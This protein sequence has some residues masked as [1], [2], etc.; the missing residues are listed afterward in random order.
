MIE[1]FAPRMP[2]G[3]SWV[4]L[5][6]VMACGVG[7]AVEAQTSGRSAGTSKTKAPQPAAEVETTKG[8]SSLPAAD[9]DEKKAATVAAEPAVSAA[10]EDAEAPN[11]GPSV[12]VFKDPRA[13][14]ILKKK[15]AAIGRPKV[16][17]LTKTVKQMAA[18]EM[19]ADRGSIERFVEGMANELTSQS[20]IVALTVPDPTGKTSRRA[21]NIKAAATDLLDMFDTAKRAK[22]QAFLNT[23]SQVLLSDKV[24][25]SLLKN[26]LFARIEAMIVLGQTG[27]TDALKV[28]VAQLK[29]PNQTVWVKLWA[30]RGITNVTEEGT[31]E[32]PTAQA[33]ETAKAVADWLDTEKDLPWPARTRGMEALGSLRHANNPAT[34]N[35]PDFAAVAMKF[36]ADP[37]ARPEVRATAGWALGMMRISPALSKFNFILVA[38]DLGEVAADL[39]EK[40][41]DAF[42]DNPMQSEY[43]TS[44]LLYQIYPA[45]EGKEGARESGLTHI[46]T[47]HPNIG[48]ASKFIKQVD[49]LVKPV[50]STAVNL[51][52]APTGR[53]KDYKKELNDRVAALKLFLEKNPPADHHLTP[54]GPQFPIKNP[55][56]AEA[57]VG[58]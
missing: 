45:L 54:G 20:N 10:E 9:K 23:Y 19:A 44:F 32:L 12:E 6:I 31:R 35:Q 36:L 55:Q 16:E 26:N 2:R 49:D 13:E 30:A 24:F 42:A 27:G 40:V 48:Q 1:A 50:A 8:P 4:L 25:L 22:N 7:A 58:K 17:G 47:N 37:E 56:V 52:R 57:P 51:L 41:S 21:L 5:S 14:E 11:K 15:Y 53:F 29:D 46:P 3:C 33:V 43:Y 18:N 38:F 34:P 39:G 28:F